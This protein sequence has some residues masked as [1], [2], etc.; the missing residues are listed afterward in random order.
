[1]IVYHLVSITVA[2]IIDMLIG[3]PPK[4]PSPN[5][6][7]ELIT[8]LAQ[9]LSVKKVA[10]VQPTFSEYEKACR[11]NKCEIH[12]HQLVEPNFEFNPVDLRKS[13]K[14]IN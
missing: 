13:L 4:H 12:Y 8:L 1:M 10:I 6:G 11:A 5:G 7:A 9:M 2:Y 3:D 14:I